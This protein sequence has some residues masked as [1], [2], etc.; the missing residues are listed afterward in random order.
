MTGKKGANG[1]SVLTKLIENTFGD[2]FA[3]PEPTLIT[4][5]REKANEA[6]EAMMDLENK[7]IAIMSEPNKKDSI[8]SDNLK[9]FT[10]GD[11]ITARGNH[12]SSKKINMNLKI[13][14]LC[15]S[16]PVKVALVQEKFLKPSMSL[17]ILFIALWSCSIILFSDS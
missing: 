11:T 12:K 7:R 5:Q 8:L 17:V 4:K 3:A 14:M 2:Y 13:F 16:I 10:G 15:N 6:N 1:K 9:K